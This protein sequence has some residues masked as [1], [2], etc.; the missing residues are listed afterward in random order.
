MATTRRDLL[1]ALAAG[2]LGLLVN[3][4]AGPGVGRP[5]RGEAADPV[6]TLVYRWRDPGLSGSPRSPSAESGETYTSAVYRAPSAF[7]AVGSRWVGGV[8]TL[9]LRASDDG[10]AWTAWHPVTTHDSESYGA[11]PAGEVFGDLLTG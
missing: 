1:R 4:G 6:E 9:E 5:P 7:N 2:G 8:G 3:L 10:T 11:R